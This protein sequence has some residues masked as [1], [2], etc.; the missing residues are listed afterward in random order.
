MTPEHKE[1]FEQYWRQFGLLEEPKP[2]SAKQAAKYL[3]VTSRRPDIT[4]NTI[5]YDTQESI[6]PGVRQ[7]V[8]FGA[9]GSMRQ[10]YAKPLNKRLTSTHNQAIKAMGKVGVKLL[11]F[12]GRQAF[13]DKL[14]AGKIHGTSLIVR[15]TMV[16]SNDPELDT[17]V[18][19]GASI[20]F[21]PVPGYES[22]GINLY[23]A[24]IM[25][26]SAAPNP[27]A[28]MLHEWAHIFGV[29]HM[30]QN[31]NI[32]HPMCMNSDAG[33][34][35]A[36]NDRLQL[37]QVR[38]QCIVDYTDCQ[39]SIMWCGPHPRC[40]EEMKPSSA[41]W[42]AIVQGYHQL[43]GEIK[44]KRKKRVPKV[45]KKGEHSRTELAQYCTGYEA[46][47]D[48]QSSPCLE[49]GMPNNLLTPQ[50][51]AFSIPDH[52]PT[53]DCYLYNDGNAALLF[54]FFFRMIRMLWR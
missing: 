14:R 9:G 3:A 7:P 42:K 25:I 41:D 24:S 44:G 46:D 27:F 48:M 51:S 18:A 29:G 50:F 16:D 39:S 8:I 32:V 34:T 5:Y 1:L 22:M 35:R 23:T 11:P 31:F 38:E 13:E 10:M 4:V 21:I 49:F 52:H 20:E 43:V 28:Y 2:C 54:L 26:N 40:T 45:K 53:V 15:V 19:G 36:Q 33:L 12:P 17:S 47:T 6:N 37:L 30:G